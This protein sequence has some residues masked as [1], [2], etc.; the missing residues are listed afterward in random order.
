MNRSAS[1]I[2]SADDLMRVFSVSRETVDRLKIYES[3]LIAGSARL[4]SSPRNA[5][6]RLVTSFCRQ[7]ADC[8]RSYPETAQKASWIWALAAGFQGWSSPPTS[9]MLVVLL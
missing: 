7:S 4:I 9:L 2:T 8:V 3:A 1:E 6:A 5:A